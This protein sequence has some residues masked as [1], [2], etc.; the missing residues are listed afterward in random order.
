MKN[1]IF[2]L[3]LTVLSCAKQ[4]ANIVA[5]SLSESPCNIKDNYDYIVT[6]KL[7]DYQTKIIKI[8]HLKGESYGFVGPEDAKYLPYYPC[9]LPNEYKVE[10][11]N[12]KMTVKLFNYN[13]ESGKPCIDTGVLPAEIL[14][15]SK[16]GIGN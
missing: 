15:I 10:G 14:S 11:L 7:V 8:K 1:L 16:N 6:G 9:N 13:C 12:I 4:D 2:I 5:D 3:S